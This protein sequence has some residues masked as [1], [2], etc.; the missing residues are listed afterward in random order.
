MAELPEKIRKVLEANKDKPFIQRVINYK[1]GESPTLDNK[2]GTISTH[3]MAANH[4]MDGKV[5]V[6]PTVVMGKGGRLRRLDDEEGEDGRPALNNALQTGNAIE[7]P[8]IRE[9][10]W[11]SENYKTGTGLANE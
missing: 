11:F 2:D 9:A 7:F 4:G 10:I 3:S 8:N 5:Y 1:E 6:Y